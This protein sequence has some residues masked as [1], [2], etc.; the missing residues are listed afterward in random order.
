MSLFL[1]VS[2]Y[3]TDGSGDM[4]SDQDKISCSYGSVLVNTNS[5][6]SM[7]LKFGIANG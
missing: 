2:V 4:R 6:V 5:H 1:G 7:C 3:S